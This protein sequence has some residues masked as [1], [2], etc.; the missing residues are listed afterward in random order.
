MA[1]SDEN[2]EDRIVDRLELN[3]HV[4]CLIDSEGHDQESRDAIA[5]IRNEIPNAA[6]VGGQFNATD[7]NGK[8]TGLTT[9]GSNMSLNTTTTTSASFGDRALRAGYYK[10]FRDRCDIVIE[11]FWKSE[12]GS[13]SEDELFEAWRLGLT[14]D[15]KPSWFG[16]RGRSDL[17][18]LRI[19][20]RAALRVSRNYFVE[21]WGLNVGKRHPCAFNL[22]VVAGLK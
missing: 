5:S 4:Q 15:G 22:H 13:H 3:N 16:K 9:S 12:L 17:F 7:A 21:S 6:V 2:P 19:L 14:K 10:L 1:N 8:L 18:N 11:H 20:P